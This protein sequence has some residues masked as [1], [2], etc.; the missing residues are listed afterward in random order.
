[1]YGRVLMVDPE[2][3]DGCLLCVV[4]CSV[5][6]TGAFEL[7]RAHITVYRADDD[8]FVPLSCHHCETPSCVE[9]CPT[10]ACHRDE[11]SRRVIIDD[12]RCIGCKTC[13]VACPFG[14]A[15]YDPIARVSTKCDYCD[16]EPQC[17]KL[18][19]PGALTYVYS[20]ECSQ[21]KKR[22]SAAVRAFMGRR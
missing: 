21:G 13:A 20:D 9:A 18:C 8:V 19:E 10:K 2:K 1:M 17:V 3:C 4:G 14:H 22:G 7:E 11:E 6:H 15:H 5:A 12:S 16:G